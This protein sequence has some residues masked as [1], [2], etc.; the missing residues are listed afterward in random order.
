MLF[1]LELNIILIVH[2]AVTVTFSAH[3]VYWDH[4]GAMA[5]R[6]IVS[7]GISDKQDEEV[8]KSVVYYGGR[9]SLCCL[10][11]QQ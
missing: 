9:R 5:S 8:N 4:L 10:Q 1:V 3:I 2:F 7:S 6:E 11:L